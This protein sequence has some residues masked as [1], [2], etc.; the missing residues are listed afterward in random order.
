[1]V[2]FGLYL[3]TL[4]FDNKLLFGSISASIAKTFLKTDTSHSPR[5]RYVLHKFVCDGS[6]IK[7]TLLGEC[8]IS[9]LC[10]DKY[11]RDFSENSYPTFSMHILRI[12]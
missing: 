2:T 11:W 8:N 5:K 6:I 10:L 1:L 4:R 9:R 12:K 7:G 3:R